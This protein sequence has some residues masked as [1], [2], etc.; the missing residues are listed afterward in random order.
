MKKVIL[1]PTVAIALVSSGYAMDKKNNPAKSGLVFEA[2][3]SANVT[4]DQTFD[5]AKDDAIALGASSTEDRNIGIGGGLFIGYDYAFHPNM[6]I[7]GKVGY[8]YM[9]EVN[10]FK[11]DVGGNDLN[12]KLNIN[13][14]PVLATWKYFF[15]SGWL[16]GVD[17]GV[18]IQRWTIDG[19]N[20]TLSVSQ[21]HDS[22]WNVAPMVGL[23]GGYKWQN[24][25]ALTGSLSYVFGHSTNDIKVNGDDD[26]DALAVWTFGLNL[27]YTLP[28]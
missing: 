12:F 5:Q 18:D 1:I 26:N 2:Q 7:G 14:F 8:R 16:V 10:Y 20:S 21:S 15:N 28:L 13:S 23:S 19:D 3:V 27:S 24:G 4:P 22:N 6:T 25:L 11:T 17:A 9:Y